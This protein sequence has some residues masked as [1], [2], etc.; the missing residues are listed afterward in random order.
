MEGPLSGKYVVTVLLTS[1]PVTVTPPPP[2]SCRD[3]STKVMGEHLRHDHPPTLPPSLSHPPPAFLSLSPPAKRRCTIQSTL[4][5]EVM[6]VD[7]AALL[8]ALALLFA[9]CSWAHQ[10]I[11]FDELINAAQAIR[12]ST[13]PL[14][15]R[16]Q[17]R[18]AVISE[19]QNLRGR[20]VRQLR[21]FCR[22]S[23]ITV[24]IDG[25][26]NVNTAKVTNV[27]LICG[28][29]AYYWCSIV[30]GSHHNTAV[31]LRDPL[32]EVLN[33][34]KAQGLAF[35]G[36]VADNERVNTT[37]WELLLAPF[38]FLLRTA[39]AAHLVQLCVLKAL[40]LPVIDPILTTMEGVIRQF[41]Y[42]VN[43][44]KLKQVMMNLSS[45][46]A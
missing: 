14:P 18:A 1:L 30:N 43:R 11:E 46:S 22:S 13:C 39:C 45:R 12:S 36:L 27:V 2:P 33:D 10:I 23:P 41:R 8:P 31:W 37:L 24:A 6:R 9:R 40:E 15:D 29:E 20:V 44:L 34:I 42:K 19:A 3:T 16:R 32:V 35:T 25:W 21:I 4:D 7:N 38:P 17:L 26:T 5:N 28:G